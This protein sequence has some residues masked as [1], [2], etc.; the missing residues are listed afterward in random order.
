MKCGIDAVHYQKFQR[1]LLSYLA[2]SSVLCLAIILP[3][4]ISQGRYGKYRHFSAQ[5][6]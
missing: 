2:V 4:N 6:S 1:Y 5:H 3:I